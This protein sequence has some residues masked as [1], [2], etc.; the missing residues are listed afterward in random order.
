MAKIDPKEGK[1]ELGDTEDT[2]LEDI[3]PDK[4]DV[5]TETTKLQQAQAAYGAYR[6]FVSFTITDKQ[7]NNVRTLDKQYTIK[8][9]KPVSDQSKLYYYLGG[10]PQLVSHQSAED[11]N[12]KKRIKAKLN[13][14]DPPVGFYP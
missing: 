7:G 11:K 4:Y 9:N 3:N 1:Y 5:N 2:V 6:W 14:G 12:G 10:P 13:L 8:I